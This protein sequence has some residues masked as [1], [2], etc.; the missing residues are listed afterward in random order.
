MVGAGQAG[1]RGWSCGTL[2]DTGSNGHQVGAGGAGVHSGADTG[3]RSCVGAGW[4]CRRVTGRSKSSSGA[5]FPTQT[6]HL[7]SGCFMSR[8]T[9]H[10]LQRQLLLYSQQGDE[11]IVRLHQ[12]KHILITPSDQIIC[13]LNDVA[14]SYR[15]KC[16]TILVKLYPSE[17]LKVNV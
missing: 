4:A 17:I 9:G 8:F 5:A 14:Y 7:F 1:G 10:E 3:A 6:L 16:C 11:K 15:Q 2:T 13:N 12:A